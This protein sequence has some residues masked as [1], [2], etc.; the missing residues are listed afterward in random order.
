MRMRYVGAIFVTWRLGEE[1]PGDSLQYMNVMNGE[2]VEDEED[3]MKSND[4]KMKVTVDVLDV[5]IVWTS[6]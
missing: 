4:N 3:E 6:W 5:Q 1:K 2:H